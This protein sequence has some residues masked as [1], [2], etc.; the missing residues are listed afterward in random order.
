MNEVITYAQNYDLNDGIK[1]FVE[2][3]NKQ[4]IDSQLTVIYKNLTPDLIGY[5]KQYS[6][7]LIDAATLDAQFNVVQNISPYTLKVI[8]FYLYS[9]NITTSTNLFLCDFTDIFFNKNPFELVKDLASVF[10]ED[11]IIGNC[12]TNTTW[13]NICYNK[14]IAGLLSSSQIVNGGLIL[15][16][17]QTC[18]D[19]LK[20]MMTEVGLVLGRIGN[21]QNI[22]QAIL[23][24][25]VHF[26][27][28]QY[29]VVT[30][31]SMI[32][33]AHFIKKTYTIQ[34]AEPISIGDLVTYVLHQYD[35]DKRLEKILNDKIYV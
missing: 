30:D 27:K 26:N 5:L 18:V 28:A 25:V 33:F 19:L 21:Y 20:E 13:L 32:N 35:C 31:H 22:D 6:V 1:V 9:K 11:E 29:N 23:N 16:T 3:F 8:Y 34:D 17:R 14:D 12:Q 24:K 2:S 4:C 7:N 10:T 15:G